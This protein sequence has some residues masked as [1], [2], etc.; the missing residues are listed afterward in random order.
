MII[1]NLSGS[2]FH[3]YSSPAMCEKCNHDK[4]EVTCGR[5]CGRGTPHQTHRCAHVTT[6][7]RLAWAMLLAPI[8]GLDRRLYLCLLLVCTSDTALDTGLSLASGGLFVLMKRWKERQVS[9]EGWQERMSWR[10]V[11]EASLVAFSFAC[12]GETQLLCVWERMQHLF[13]I[14][15]AFVAQLI[16]ILNVCLLKSH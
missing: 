12:K 4:Q 13:P 10:T 15:T 6:H 14:F 11:V 2:V 8:D 16:F 7:L 3:H 5:G 9:Q 1:D